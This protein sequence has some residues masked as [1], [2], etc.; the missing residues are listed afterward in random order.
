MR[1]SPIVEIF[2]DVLNKK[3]AYEIMVVF[4]VSVDEAGDYSFKFYGFV[5]FY[6]TQPFRAL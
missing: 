3:G 6:D 2:L 1:G 4:A 5:N